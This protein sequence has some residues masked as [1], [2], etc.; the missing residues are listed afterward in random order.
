MA[1]TKTCPVTGEKVTPRKNGSGKMKGEAGNARQ[2]GKG[3][4]RRGKKEKA[5]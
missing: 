3:P 4:K 1:K 2:N 5:Q